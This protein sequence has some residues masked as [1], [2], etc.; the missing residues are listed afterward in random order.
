MLP[1][2]TLPALF[3]GQGIP[4]AQYKDPGFNNL[5]WVQS[6]NYNQ[7]PANTVIDTIV[8][9][10]TAGATLESCVKWFA[11][12]ESRVSAHFTVGKDGSIVQHVSTFERA[13][14]AGASRDHRGRENLNNFTIGIEMVNIGDGKDPWTKEQVEVVGYLIGTLKRRFPEIKYITSHEFIATPRGRKPDPKNFPWASLDNHGLELWYDMAK[15]VD[16]PAEAL[17]H[18][19]SLGLGDVE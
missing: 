19:D 5:V 16:P 9:H 12:T 8:L 18:P 13:W 4:L 6:P 11:T 17:I 3:L 10:H 14:H 1:L 7:R 2:V 15:R